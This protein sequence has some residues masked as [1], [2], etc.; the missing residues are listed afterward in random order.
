M[1]I[2]KTMNDSDYMA[3]AFKEAQKVGKGKEYPVGALIVLNGEVISTARN[4]AVEDYDP[5]S[6]AEIN[7]IRVACNKIKS[8]KLK[9]AILYTTLYPCPMCEAAITETGIKK[10]V[11][12]AEPFVWIREVKFKKGNLEF[13]GPILNEECRNIFAEKL[14]ELGRN[15][16]LNYNGS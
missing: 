16:I 4:T 10:G 14:R 1:S 6:H 2:I 8:H 5:T 7:A 15:D 11:Y 9:D 12:G 3:L 13:V